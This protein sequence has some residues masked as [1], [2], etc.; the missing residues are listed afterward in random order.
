RE[1]RV[2]RQRELDG[3][4]AQR[5][6]DDGGV[7]VVDRQSEERA[8][9]LLGGR[10]LAIGAGQ[11]PAELARPAHQRG[12]ELRAN[13]LRLLLDVEPREDENDL[14]AEAADS[15]QADLG[16]GRRRFATHAVDAD[17]VFPLLAE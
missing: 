14:V 11:A 2:A 1:P 4:V 6:P 16:G 7:G 5:T 12:L 13:E 10:V 3:G 15:V 8:R 17:A 9:L